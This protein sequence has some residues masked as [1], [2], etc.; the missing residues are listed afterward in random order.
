M[1]NVERLLKLAEHLKSGKLGHEIFNFST[2]NSSEYLDSFK[3]PTNKYDDPRLKHC[4]TCGCAIGECPFVF[5]EWLFDEFSMPVIAKYSDLPKSIDD[6]WKSSSDATHLSGM[7]FFEIDK[8]EFSQL[9]MPCGQYPLIY[10][11]IDLNSKSTPMEVAQNIIIFC[12]R[13]KK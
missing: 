2:Y 12:E 13:Q 7:E 4:S 5:E 3:P 11:G 8:R 6:D 9:F 1:A 10:G